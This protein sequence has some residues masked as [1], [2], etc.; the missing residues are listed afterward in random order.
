M[1]KRAMAAEPW[2]AW[3]IAVSLL[4]WFAARLV[5]ESLVIGI[6]T[7]SDGFL[8]PYYY[9]LVF[10]V[11]LMLVF[12]SFTLS[13]RIPLILVYLMY[14]AWLFSQ[15][16]YFFYYN[17]PMDILGVMTVAGDGIKAFVHGSTMFRIELLLPLADLPVF[18][19]FLVMYTPIN[20]TIRKIRQKKIYVL[21]ILALFLFFQIYFLLGEAKEKELSHNDLIRKHGLLVFS[22]ARSFIFSPDN[23]E[24]LVSL[25]QDDGTVFKRDLNGK[26]TRIINNPAYGFKKWPGQ[27]SA[28][29]SFLLI[30]VESLQ[31]GMEKIRHNGKLVMPYLNALSGQSLY[32][33]YCFAYHTAGGTSDCEVSVFNNIEPV[34][35]KRMTSRN[36][37]HEN[38]FL[39]LMPAYHKYVFHN[40]IKGFFNR[41]NSYPKIGFNHFYDFDEME[42]PGKAWGSEDRLMWEYIIN[43]RDKW[44]EPFLYYAITLTSHPGFGH[45]VNYHNADFLADIKRKRDRDALNSFNY[46]DIELSKFIPKFRALFPNAWIFIYGDHSLA[47]VE[48]AGHLVRSAVTLHEDFLEMVPLFILTPDNKAERFENTL[49][50]FHDLGPTVL[51]LSKRPADSEYIAYPAYGGSLLYDDVQSMAVPFNGKLLKRDTILNAIRELI[52]PYFVSER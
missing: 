41:G 4:V 31:C 21:A 34:D 46:V 13:S 7:S 16:N 11:F 8:F 52:E 45:I 48:F 37:D 3:K 20:M 32:Y 27:S 19:F 10:P 2:Q 38:S 6:E 30:Q 28:D 39:K 35:G 25:E 22:F 5:I 18:I 50:S 33:P 23:R 51:S 36:F 9:L 40:Y 1:K 24:V 14:S 42:L 29:V 44:K 26:L 49:A 17:I 12:F 43:H 15:I 47:T